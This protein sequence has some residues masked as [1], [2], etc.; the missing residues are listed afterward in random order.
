M[1][2]S[3]RLHPVIKLAEKAEQEALTALGQANA[4]WHHDKTQLDDLH[5]YKADY[6]QRFRQGEM[7]MLSA[8]KMMDLRAFLEQLDQAIKAQQLQVEQSYSVVEYQKGLWM[9]KRT[10]TQA[11]QLLV[12]RYQ[13]EEL[14]IA[15]RKEQR[16]NDEHS[17]NKWLRNRIKS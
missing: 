13:G 4:S 17:T 16:D 14:A 15:L 3:K 1:S 12:E 5:Q 6:L 2:R 9:Q 7:L 11:L 8:Q 10:K